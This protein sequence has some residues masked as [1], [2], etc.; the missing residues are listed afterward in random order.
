MKNLEEKK[1]LVQMAQMLGE[2][3]DPLLLES[4]EKEEQLSKIM[5]GEEAEPIL[6]EVVEEKETLLIEADPFPKFVRLP[7]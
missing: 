6:E 7:L 4:I 5:F 2:P 3:V 1:L